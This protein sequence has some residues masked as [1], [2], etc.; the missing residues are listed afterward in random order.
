LKW[1]ASAIALKDRDREEQRRIREQIREEERA[2]REIERALRDAAK[3]E[4][5]LRKAMT[6]ALAQAARANDEQRTAFEM[7]VAEL[8]RRLAE[9]EV[10][11]QRALSMAQQTKAGHVYVISNV[12]SFGEHVFKVGMTRRLDPLDRVR[13]LGDAS[14]PFPFDIHAMTWAEDAP[15][16]ENVLHKR[17][18]ADQVNKVN[19]RKEFFKISLESLRGVVEERGLQTTWTLAAAAS[20][21]RE[22][23]AIENE[24]AGQT[25]AARAWL[26]SQLDLADDAFV[27]MA[28]TED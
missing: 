25:P 18:V 14:V 15:A 11:N 24:L 7:Q 4:D 12:G 10:K 13:E 20:Q 6:K 9:A 28:E 5:G 27:P 22:T 21:Y 1:A 3:E 2:R 26:D 17:F 16:L 8:E 23:L 19:P